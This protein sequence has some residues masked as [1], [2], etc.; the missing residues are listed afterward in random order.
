MATVL[1]GQ[2]KSRQDTWQLEPSEVP[3]KVPEDNGVLVNNTLGG[4]GLVALIHQQALQLLP[5]NQRAEVGHCHRG[6]GWRRRPSTPTALLSLRGSCRWLSRTVSHGHFGLRIEWC[7][8]VLLYNRI[9]FL[10][11]PEGRH[12]I[13]LFKEASGINEVWSVCGSAR[14]QNRH[15][16]WIQRWG[17]G[18]TGASWNLSS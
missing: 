18:G 17:Q 4:D 3:H 16:G 12:T 9:T 8:R 14:Q 15:Q 2:D 10:R 1:G 5:Q 7:R 6:G 13:Y 11:G